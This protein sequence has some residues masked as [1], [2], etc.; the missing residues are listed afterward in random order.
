V[1]VDPIKPKLKPP[2]TKRLKLKCDILLSTSAFKFNLRR[3]NQVVEVT[4]AGT[5]RY[6]FYPKVGP[7]LPNIARRDI[8][9]IL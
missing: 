6:K 4:P 7:G 3:Y 9:R 8:Q 2:G 5:R 1:Q